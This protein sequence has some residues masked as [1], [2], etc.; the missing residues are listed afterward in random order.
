MDGHNHKTEQRNLIMYA[1]SIRAQRMRLL[2]E[3]LR[4]LELREAQLLAH[5]NQGGR[6]DLFS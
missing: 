4:R 6:R 3:K 1:I 5:Q 2:K